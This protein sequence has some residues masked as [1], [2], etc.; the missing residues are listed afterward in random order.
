MV[1]TY[2][3]HPESPLVYM[4]VFRCQEIAEEFVA[5]RIKL[6]PNFTVLIK[7]LPKG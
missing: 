3:N 6:N 5:L 1:I 7:E 4:R 2:K